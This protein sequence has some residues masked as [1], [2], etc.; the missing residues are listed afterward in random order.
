MSYNTN[1]SLT[2]VASDVQLQPASR[3]S[4]AGPRCCRIS[5]FKT[6]NGG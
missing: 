5:G 3:T 6:E 2:V 4:L 1:V